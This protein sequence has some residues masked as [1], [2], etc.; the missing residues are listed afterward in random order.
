[1]VVTKFAGI[2]FSSVLKKLTAVRLESL[3]Y[4]QNNISA[5]EKIISYNETIRMRNLHLHKILGLI[6]DN[7]NSVNADRSQRERR[8]YPKDKFYASYLK[9]IKKSLLTVNIS[10]NF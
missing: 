4:L 6:M 10:T 2:T 3:G 9:K 8:Q 5:I 1:M 7:N